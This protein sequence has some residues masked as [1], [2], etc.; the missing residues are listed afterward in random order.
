LPV[1]TAR[2]IED[3]YAGVL[4]TEVWRRGLEALARE[5]G[6]HG[7][8]LASYDGASGERL[9]VESAPVQLADVAPLQLHPRSTLTAGATFGE[10][11]GLCLHRTR[12]RLVMLWLPGR[13]GA[14]AGA[15]FDTDH[16]WIAHL[17]RALHLRERIE[18]ATLHSS[19]L[20]A[21]VE[22]VS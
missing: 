19:V 14:A 6:A 12:E 2:L 10:R 7:L 16:P 8:V 11:R 18:T 5:W 21:S 20:D 9:R 4:D 22:R 1:V 13:D 17:L 15:D 3:L